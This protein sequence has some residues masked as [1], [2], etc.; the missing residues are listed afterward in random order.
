MMFRRFVAVALMTLALAA[1]AQAYGGRE[2]GGEYGGPRGDGYG[3]RGGGFDAPRGGY[4]G[5]ERGFGPGPEDRGGY[6]GPVQA[7]YR[8]RDRG[9]RPTPQ[10]PRN[11]QGP[12]G[13]PM[14]RRVPGPAYRLPGPAYGAPERGLSRGQYMPPQAR[15]AVVQDFARY[16]LRRPPRGYYW[17]RAGDDFVL[18]SVTSGVIFEVIPAEGY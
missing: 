7:P 18:A 11:P 10:P 13:G 8:D 16:H 12:Q 2:R 9:P 3:E 5:G 14:T 4:G 15:G 1:Q 6:R 17:Y